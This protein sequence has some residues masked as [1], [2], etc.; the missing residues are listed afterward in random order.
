MRI[1]RRVF[2]VLLLPDSG[3]TGSRSLATELD[4]TVGVSANLF[5]SRPTAAYSV[6]T[7]RKGTKRILKSVDSNEKIVY[8]VCRT[9]LTCCVF[10]LIAQRRFCNRL[11]TVGLHVFSFL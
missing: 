9:L 3:T 5:C 1:E 8:V 10:W 6:M 2:L 7:T 11:I 4:A